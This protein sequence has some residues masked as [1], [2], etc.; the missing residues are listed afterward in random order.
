MVGAHAHGLAIFER[1]PRRHQNK[2]A[3]WWCPAAAPHGEM[4]HIHIGAGSLLC[5]PAGPPTHHQRHQTGKVG[6]KKLKKL[7]AQRHVVARLRCG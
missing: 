5:R 3:R 2:E 1:A 4:L 7:R 6:T